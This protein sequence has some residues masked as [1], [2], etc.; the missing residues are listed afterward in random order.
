[1]IIK[2]T[3]WSING[4]IVLQQ[5]YYAYIVTCHK[6]YFGTVIV[7]DM[8]NSYKL[9]YEYDIT[10]DN[11]ITTHTYLNTGAFLN[12]AVE[13]PIPENITTLVFYLPKDKEINNLTAN[14][15]IGVVREGVIVK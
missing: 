4:I 10:L 11:T 2:A 8:D 14:Y 1:M 7:T 3:D 9:V 15:I 6:T 5:V 12:L 13:R